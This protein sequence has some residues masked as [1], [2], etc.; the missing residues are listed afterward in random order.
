[1]PESL[2]KKL[3]LKPGQKLYLSNTPPGYMEK[4]ASDLPDLIATTHGEKD[5]ILIFVNNMA[6][7]ET[8]VAPMLVGLKQDTLFLVGYPKGTSKIKTDVNR[9]TL[10]KAMEP[11]GW[12][13]IRLIS[14]DETWSVMRFRPADQVGK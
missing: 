2:V 10:W 8:L 5:A 13:P 9:D 12:R 4:L 3:Q 7:A 14:L 11:T 1:M 6:E